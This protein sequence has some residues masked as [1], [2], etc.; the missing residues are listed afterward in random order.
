MT[1]ASKAKTTR[2]ATKTANPSVAAFLPTDIFAFKPD[3]FK[4]APVAD[5]IRAATEKS[6]EQAR[7]KYETMKSAAEE[8]T[9]ALENTLENARK[10]TLTFNQ[11]IIDT[12]K[13][14]SDAT[15]AFWKKMISAKTMSEAIELQTSFARDRFDA[16][17]KQ[18]KDIQT[19]AQKAAEETA[20]PV[21]QA[22]QKT[23]DNVKA[24]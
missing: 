22:V 1:T 12:A 8:A 17:S 4:S 23:M 2:T 14:N 16:F 6:L 20:K 19:F 24:A 7:S 21:T 18:A 13:N 3:S 10:N 15:F 11:K 5:S 9:D